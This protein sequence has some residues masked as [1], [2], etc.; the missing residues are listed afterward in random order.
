MPLASQHC[1]KC[2]VALHKKGCW[3]CLENT[4]PKTSKLPFCNI[5][6]RDMRLDICCV[7]SLCGYNITKG[8]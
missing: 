5:C 6:G 3:N 8:E 7:N 2:G 1:P 4:E